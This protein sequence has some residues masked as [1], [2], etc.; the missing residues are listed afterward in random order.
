M[1]HMVKVQRV[2]NGIFESKNHFIE[3]LEEAIAFI[4]KHPDAHCRIFDEN[5]EFKHE[6]HPVGTVT[7]DV[8]ASLSAS[9]N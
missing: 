2:I 3:S 9:V 7:I 6:R 5:G 4:E 1:A 8:P